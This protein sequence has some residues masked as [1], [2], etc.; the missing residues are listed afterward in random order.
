[1]NHIKMVVESV[2]CGSVTENVMNRSERD[3]TVEA[4]LALDGV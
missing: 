4:R 3:E 2:P 1:M